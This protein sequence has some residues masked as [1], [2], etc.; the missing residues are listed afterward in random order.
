MKSFILPLVFLFGGLPLFGEKI[1]LVTNEYPPY[2]DPRAEGGGTMTRR[3]RRVAEDLGWEIEIGFYPWARCEAM[4]R[5]G[6]AFGA[7][8]YAKNK[9]RGKY[10]YFSN[11]LDRSQIVLF[12]YAGESGAGAPPLPVWDS[13]EDLKDLRMGAIL[14]YWYMEEF[15]QA[16]LNLSRVPDMETGLNRLRQGKIDLLPGDSEVT[17]HHLRRFFP[18]EEGAFRSLGKPFAV[19]ALHLMVSKEYPDSGNLMME[20]NRAL[21]RL[22]QD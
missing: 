19:N 17:R 16:G 20:F 4:V 2:V 3:I 7:F 15:Q 6:E 18:G 9:A 5:R 1:L 10:A 12:Y 8:P 11:T 21:S 13:L 22:P 14:G